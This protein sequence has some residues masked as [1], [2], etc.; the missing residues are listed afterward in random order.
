MGTEQGMFGKVRF[1][2]EVPVSIPCTSS[3]NR[4]NTAARDI[5]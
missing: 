5:I 3:L 1:E 2:N 4:Y